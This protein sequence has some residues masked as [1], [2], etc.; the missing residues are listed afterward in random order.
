MSRAD[1]SIILKPRLSYSLSWGLPLIVFSMFW[2][3]VLMYAI[4]IKPDIIDSPATIVVFV[5]LLSVLFWGVT[6]I[7][8][9]INGLPQLTASK[10]AIEMR[11]IWGVRKQAF[12]GLGEI[13]VIKNALSK[14]KRIAVGKIIIDDR[15]QAP[16]EEIVE[17]ING[18]RK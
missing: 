11:S 8:D 16:L 9:A 1:A 6:Y 3:F 18:R 4:N 14:P 7:S 5:M 13:T 15:Y 12:A 2:L 10:T 17:I